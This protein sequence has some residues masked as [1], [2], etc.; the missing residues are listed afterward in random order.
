MKRR[1]S[2][3]DRR[4]RF[5]E[6][7][8]AAHK[9]LIPEDSL[10]YFHELQSFEHELINI[11]DRLGQLTL[12]V[13]GTDDHH[14][15]SSM[16]AAYSRMSPDA[17]SAHGTLSRDTTSGA[18]A[19]AK[20]SEESS[21]E[22]SNLDEPIGPALPISLTTRDFEIPEPSMMQMK[23][24]WMHEYREELISLRKQLERANIDRSHW[25][26]FV[27]KR[28]ER[29]YHRQQLIHQDTT[30]RAEADEEGAGEEEAREEEV[31]DFFKFIER[32]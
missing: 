13:L 14:Q 9:A 4:R 26:S 3:H 7:S 6:S 19:D 5:I 10:S 1:V 22:F 21:F 23:L 16:A 25:F 29:Q 32:G 11:D 12:D 8:E 18:H 2:A 17:T 20:S 27:E 28:A 31:A 24:Q 15:V 30:L